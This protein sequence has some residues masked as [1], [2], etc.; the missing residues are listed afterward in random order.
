MD[1]ATEPDRYTYYPFGAGPRICLGNMFAMLEAQVILA[2][3]MQQV[4]LK[5]AISEPVKLGSRVTLR[6]VDPLTVTVEKRPLPSTPT[7]PAELITT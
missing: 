4:N 7:L 1:K 2:T 6:P 5:L 3:M